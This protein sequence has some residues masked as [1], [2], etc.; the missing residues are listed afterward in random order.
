MN[1]LIGATPLISGYAM[2]QICPMT[3]RAGENIPARPPAWT[4]GIVWPLLYIAMGIAWVRTRQSANSD[5]L[6]ILLTGCLLLWQYFYSCQGKTKAA[7]YTLVAAVAAALGTALW[8]NSK[9][10]VSSLL[11]VPLIVWLIFATMLN[12]TIVNI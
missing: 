11:L 5:V 7:L 2:G 9:D 4:F 8:I 12:Y 3:S 1:L 6:F 10:R